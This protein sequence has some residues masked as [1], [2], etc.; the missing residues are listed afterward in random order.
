[1]FPSPRTASAARLLASSLLA[2]VVTMVSSPPAA[3]G[4]IADTWAWPVEPPWQIERGY[5]APPTPYGIGHRGIDLAAPQAT[6]VLAPA[7][8]TVLFAGTV[9]DRGV[10]SIDHGNGVTSSYEPVAAAVVTGQRVQSGD[11]VGVVSGLHT[12]PSGACACV[13]MGTRVNGEYLSPLAFLSAI[14]RA[15]LL[16]WRD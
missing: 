11:V 10:I 8:G 4:A 3:R 2:V 12:W 5:L 6:P 15:V 1:M 14:D 9:V 7:S 16:P 13:H